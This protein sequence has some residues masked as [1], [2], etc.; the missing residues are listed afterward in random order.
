MALSEQDR[1]VDEPLRR[2]I[3]LILSGGGARAAYQVGV[4]KA[5]S[6]LLPRDAVNPFPILCG[7]SAGAINATVLAIYATRFR[8]GVKRLTLVWKMFRPDMVY[9]SDARGMLMSSAHWFAAMV[10]GGLGKYN[11]T[12]LLDSSPLHQLLERYVPCDKIQDSIDAGALRAL[13]VTASGYTSGEAVSFYQGTAD[14]R[15]WKRA[16]RVGSA[17]KITAAHLLASAAIPFVF[18]AVKVNR[19]YFGDGSTGQLAP[20]SPALHLGAD[21][22]LV[23]G[24]RQP[25]SEDTPRSRVES[26][27]SLAEVAGHVLNSIF[28]ESLEADL[29]RLQRINRTISVISPEDRERAGIQL[30][31]VEVLVIA[32]SVDLGE[33]AQQYSHYLPRPV[34]LL[35][36]GIGVKNHSGA[37]LLSYLLFEKAYCRKLIS[38]GYADTMQRKTEVMRFLHLQP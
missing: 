4:L 25:D 37:S 28:L 22:V 30:R 27:P 31:P 15:P 36:R 5:I 33:L 20:I 1:F 32:P 29:E 9:R 17:T 2:K 34:R 13:C 24:V 35:L 8:E 18:P 38:L 14:L 3:G 10:L 19:E 16:R 7:T 6:Q 26:Y 11:P 21:R 23:I 12:S